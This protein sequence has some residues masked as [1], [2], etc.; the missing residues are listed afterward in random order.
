MNASLVGRL[1]PLILGLVAASLLP[2]FDWAFATNSPNSPNAASAATTPQEAEELAEKVRHTRQTLVESEAAKRRILGSLYSINQR[3]K[4]ISS[5]K[6]KMTDELFQV[7]DNVKS[8]ARVI[9]GLEVQIDKQRVQLKRRLRALYKLSGEGFLG[10]VFSQS[11]APE[12]DQTMRY[13][14]I[15]T[16]NDYRLIRNYQENIAAYL[17]QKKKL[18]GQVE[19]LVSVERKIKKQETMLLAEHK[20]KSELASE[21]DRDRSAQ[22]SMI[23]KLRTR[24]QA[25]Q[26]QSAMA[27]DAYADL[28]RPS[29]FEQ[30]GQL[31]APVTGPVI[32]EFGLLTDEKYKIQL[33]HK[34]WRY[35]VS[36]G[37]PVNSI[38]DGTVLYADQVN[39]YGQT[40]VIDHGDH[41]YSVYSHLGRIK[42]KAGD[43][44][45]KSQ[46]I[47]EAGAATRRNR[48]GVY[49][50]IRHFS[51]PEN[52]SGWI[53]KKAIQISPHNQEN[54]KPAAEMARAGES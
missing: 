52:P 26:A 42:V 3:M 14:K 35:S 44:I 37:T 50:E 20:A 24:S 25:L 27:D 38:F 16:D 47:A 51:E 12:L 43:A 17:S 10:V 22:L 39:G 31:P 2:S 15:V 1:K 36:K 8:I 19:R 28:L 21:I 45:K 48:D 53:A 5:E 46:A 18:K 54:E 30:K 41:Y 32:Q 40:L 49:F 29:I 11:S 6:G 34:G 33:S 23:K 13:L 7:Q 9:A 4:K